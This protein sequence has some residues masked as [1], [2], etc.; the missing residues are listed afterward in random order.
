MNQGLKTQI[1]LLE[2]QKN[3]SESKLS[4]SNF[5]GAINITNDEGAKK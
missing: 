3:E 1:L 4:V 2:L 5:L